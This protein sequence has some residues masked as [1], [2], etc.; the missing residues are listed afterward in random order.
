MMKIKQHDIAVYLNAIDRQMCEALIREFKAGIKFGEV[1]EGVVSAEGV[2]A[3]RSDDF[4]V[5]KDIHMV[6]HERWDDINAELHRN[7]II[8]CLSDYLD[9]YKYIVK[10]ES[11]VDP[12]SCIISMYEKGQGRFSPHQ[13]HIGGVD[14]S[15]T[16][17]CYLN[18]VYE[19]GETEF[20]NQN[21][22]VQPVEGTILVFPS[23]FVYAHQGVTP[24]S[25]DKFITVS[26]VS[27]DVGVAELADKH[28]KGSDRLLG[29]SND[30]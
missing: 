29:G 5:S 30:G 15:L 19:G 11:V 6:Q 13:D 12:E 27:V 4:L 2:Q 1:I 18:S 26:F 14:R 21:F 20:F 24:V 8:P 3:Y 17:I 7:Y 25:Q 9:N 23:N 10:S 16:V 22:K 28:K